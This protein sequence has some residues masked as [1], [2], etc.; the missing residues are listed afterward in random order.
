M[1]SDLHK[2]FRV[3]RSASSL[4]Q[5]VARRTRH[6]R[7]VWQIAR[8]CNSATFPSLTSKQP[9]FL[10]P[11]WKTTLKQIIFYDIKYLR[12][13]QLLSLYIKYGICLNSATNRKLLHLTVI[14]ESRTCQTNRTVLVSFHKQLCTF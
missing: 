9:L 10:F 5:A 1:L 4:L 13:S 7:T 11:A 6:R 3:K 2:G 14:I 8:F 12:R